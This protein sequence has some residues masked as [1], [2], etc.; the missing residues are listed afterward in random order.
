MTF[1]FENFTFKEFLHIA[2]A[3]EVPIAV[4]VGD[5]YARAFLNHTAAHWAQVFM[6]LACTPDALIAMSEWYDYD[7]GCTNTVR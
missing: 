2:T 1:A 3:P 5:P 7:C 6:L 4:L